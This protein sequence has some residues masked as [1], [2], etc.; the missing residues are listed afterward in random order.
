MTKWIV[1]DVV[2][3]LLVCALRIP[4]IAYGTKRAVLY[5]VVLGGLDGIIFGRINVSACDRPIDGF[6]PSDANAYNYVSQILGY[7][8]AILAALWKCKHTSTPPSFG[9]WLIS[10]CAPS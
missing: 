6:K 3:V 8:T 7:M 4:G 1:L 10:S 9:C 5:A 2:A